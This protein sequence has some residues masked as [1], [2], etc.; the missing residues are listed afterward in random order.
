MTTVVFRYL[1]F[2]KKYCY[3]LSCSQAEIIENDVVWN[4]FE[5]RNVC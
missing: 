2:T 5:S 3:N 4:A 1:I